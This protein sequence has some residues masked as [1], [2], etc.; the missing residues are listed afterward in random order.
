[1]AIDV[2]VVADYQ[3]QTGENPLW[4]TDEQRLYWTDIPPGRLFRLDP[5]SGEHEQVYHGRP[6]G[7]FTFQRDGSLSLFMDRGPV[8]VFTDGKLAATVIEEI[9]DEASTRFND[10]IADPEGRVFCGTMPTSERPGRLYRLDTDGSISLLLEGIGCSNGM[11]LTADLKTFYYTDSKVRQIYAFDYDRATGDIRNKRVFIDSSDGS[12][13]PDGMTVDSMDH[14]WSARWDGHRVDHYDASGQQIEA[15]E[16]PAKKIPAVTFGGAAMDTMFATTA[17]G[18][19]KNENG[20]A[21]GSI[22]MWKPGVK[23]RPEFRSAIEV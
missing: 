23:G 14:L 12:G 4:H 18:D 20:D 2:Q 3:T 13:V 17:G 19:K 5:Q 21:A 16:L 22:L 9:P 10:V 8:A 1:M 15:V 11:G 6:V 7:G